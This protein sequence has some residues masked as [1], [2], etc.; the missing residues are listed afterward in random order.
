MYINMSAQGLIRVEHVKWPARR[1]A[2]G[3]GGGAH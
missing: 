2:G 1:C 3:V